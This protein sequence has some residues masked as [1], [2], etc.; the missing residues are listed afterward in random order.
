MAK[1]RKDPDQKTSCVFRL[2][3]GYQVPMELMR[4][5][6]ACMAHLANALIGEFALAR[7]K[8]EGS[9]DKGLEALTSEILDCVLRLTQEEKDNLLRSI[10]FEFACK[11][12]SRLEK[13]SR[14][15]TDRG[16]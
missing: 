12:W 13:R 9:W 15:K 3:T 16:Q 4:V 8:E 6:T 1:R 10:V 7:A 14:E 5:T 11:S 2:S